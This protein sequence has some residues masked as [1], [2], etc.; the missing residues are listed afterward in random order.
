MTQNKTSSDNKYSQICECFVCPI[1]SV[2]K[3][4]QMDLAD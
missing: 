1:N 4:I 2:K 3:K